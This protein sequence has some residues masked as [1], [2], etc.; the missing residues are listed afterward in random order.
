VGDGEEGLP[1]LW[2]MVRKR[3]P[4]LWVMVEGLPDMRMV[5]R[6]DYLTFG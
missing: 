2:V 3:L 4:D 6:K 1:Y 5:V